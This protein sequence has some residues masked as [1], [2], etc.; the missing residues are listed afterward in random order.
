MAASLV[1]HALDWLT[2]VGEVY[3]GLALIGSPVTLAEALVIESL[4]H[5]I[6]GAAFA[7]PGAFGAQEGGL[8]VLCA[9]FG[10]PPDRAMALSLLKR[11]ADLATGLPG[12]LAWQWMESRRWRRKPEGSADPSAKG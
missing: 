1:L 7:I 5:A 10:I 12:L 6:R 2:G 8:I 11:V 4:T 9:L 3:I